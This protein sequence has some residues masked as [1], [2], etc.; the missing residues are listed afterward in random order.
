LSGGGN[1]FNEV[2]YERPIRAGDVVTV[3]T[4]YSEVY[5]KNGRSGTLL[6]RVRANDL[7]DAD[8]DRIGSTRMGHVLAFERVEAR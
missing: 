7:L 5:V 2:V 8:G 6:F 1:A 3:T 4:R